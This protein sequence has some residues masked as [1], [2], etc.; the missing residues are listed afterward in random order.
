MLLLS[1]LLGVGLATVPL[2]DGRLS[3]LSEMRPRAPWLLVAGLGMQAG[4]GLLPL[5]EI[6]GRGLHLASYALAAIFVALNLALPG[7]VLVS[8][9]GASNL[10][11]I[12]ANGGVMPASPSAL[13]RAGVALASSGFSNSE[14]L[15]H[16]RLP[17][18]GDVFALP[19]SWPL[20]NVFSI[21]D[22]LIAIGAFT[23]IH[24]LCGSRLG[25]LS[26]RGATLQGYWSLFLIDSVNGSWKSMARSGSVSS[27]AGSWVEAP[28]AS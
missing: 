20:A 12:V 27:G 2:L 14:A 17:W 16:P 7:L 25:A 6:A 11:V 24:V 8:L 10:A 18:L 15:A 23:M 4:A 3:R 26:R 1:I 5:P 28:P 9:G 13:G 21:G 22:V 19:V